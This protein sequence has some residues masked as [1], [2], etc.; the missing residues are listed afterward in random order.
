LDEQKNEQIAFYTRAKEV[1]A[2]TGIDINTVIQ[3]WRNQNQP[4]PQTLTTEEN[5]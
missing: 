2:A 1:A 4:T 3:G 5:I